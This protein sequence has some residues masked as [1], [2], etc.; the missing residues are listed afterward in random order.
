MI[1]VEALDR[2]FEGEEFDYRNWRN[3][4]RPYFV[5]GIIQTPYKAYQQLKPEYK[6]LIINWIGHEPRRGE[7]E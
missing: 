5:S 3:P 6:K 7:G 2:L 4:I 1:L